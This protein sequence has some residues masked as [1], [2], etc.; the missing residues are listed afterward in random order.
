SQLH[1]ATEQDREIGKSTIDLVQKRDLVLRD[2]GYF[3][4][5]EFQ[6][7][8]QKQAFWLSRVPSNLLIA[9][10]DGTS[11]DE[12]LESSTT[13]TVDIAVQLGAAGH[14]ARLVA[15]KALPQ[16]AEKARR[17][18]REAASKTGKTPTRSRLLRCGWHI[19]VTN[20]A[21]TMMKAAEVSELYRCRWRIE[22]IFRAWKQSANLG[23]ALNRK[24]NENH[25][26]VLILAAMIYQ[27]LSLKAVS[28]VRRRLKKHQ[29]ISL[30][31]LLDDFA[32]ACTK[33][34]HLEALW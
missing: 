34:V 23:P 13:D 6:R 28:F 27:A 10:K 18:V 8:E 11:L 1:L 19:V 5:A 4:L 24:S 2:R 7:V 12:H 15:I 26:Q 3:S 33:S 16:V 22:I 30:E 9:P 29:R 32:N 25:F 21:Q 14:S 17:E 20:I 31:K